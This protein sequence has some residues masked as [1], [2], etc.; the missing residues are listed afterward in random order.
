MILSKNEDVKSFGAECPNCQSYDITVGFMATDNY[1]E[2]QC[3]SC[4]A[5]WVETYELTG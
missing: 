4:K 3:N 2:V 5:N 1:R